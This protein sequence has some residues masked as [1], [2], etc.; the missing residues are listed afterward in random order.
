[1]FGSEMIYD[2]ITEYTQKFSGEAFSNL[3][4]PYPTRNRHSQVPRWLRQGHGGGTGRRAPAS[5]AR[6]GGA[7][8]RELGPA[9][10]HLAIHGPREHVRTDGSGVSSAVLVATLAGSARGGRSGD[11]KGLHQFS[12]R[13]DSIESHPIII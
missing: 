3:R 1:M 9:Q 8:L 4:W 7:P 13:L 2:M 10:C 11:D 6:R 5:R 12:R